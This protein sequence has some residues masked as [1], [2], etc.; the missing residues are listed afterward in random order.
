MDN[1]PSVVITAD[2][3]QVWTMLR[4]P[5]WV[6]QWHGWEAPDLDAEVKEIY[7][8]ANVT[9]AP[10]HTRLTVNGGDTFVLQPVPTGT[11]VSITRAATEPGSDSAAWDADIN[12]GWLTFLQQLRFAL[13]RHPHSSRRTIFADVP[14]EP[15][16]A[17]AKLGL[18][19]LPAPGEDYRLTLSTGELIK[20]KVWFRSADQVGLTVDEYADHGEGLLVVADQAVIANVRPHGG[21][22]V[23]VSTYG[24]GATRLASL[25]SSWDSW[26]AENYPTVQ[27]AN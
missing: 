7:F 6:V 2:A 4:T 25:R 12:Q 9:E 20:G 11:R 3:P 5:A 19:N 26:C 10:D 22:L 21:S 24:L 8:S 1:T 13:E 15:G 14:G 23:I 27:Q 17:I 16:S 18:A